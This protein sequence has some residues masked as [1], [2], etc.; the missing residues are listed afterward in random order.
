MVQ[1]SRRLYKFVVTSEDEGQ[2]LQMSDDDTVRA[3]FKENG[4]YWTIV[5]RIGKY[6][7]DAF[8]AAGPQ[9]YDNPDGGGF[10]RFTDAELFGCTPSE[11]QETQR[12]ERGLEAPK[13]DPAELRAQVQEILARLQGVRTEG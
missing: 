9:V 8:N 7:A 2:I 10:V 13:V 5:S 3:Y 12:E 1:R 6:N 11:D 4:G